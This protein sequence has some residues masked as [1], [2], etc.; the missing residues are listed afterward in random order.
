MAVPDK[1]HLPWVEIDPSLAH[2]GIPGELGEFVGPALGDN[3]KTK[4]QDIKTIFTSVMTTAASISM[5]PEANKEG[6]PG[7]NIVEETLRALN[8]LFERVLDRTQTLSTSTFEWCHATPPYEDL[9]LRP[10]RYPL[11]QTFADQVVHYLLGT[12]V[13][14]AEMNRNANHSSL[15][16]NTAE[17]IMAPMYHL[18]ALIA[19]DYFDKEVSGE[20]SLQEMIVLMTG[21]KKVGPTI[22]PSGESQELVD[23]A[24]LTDALSGIDLLQ[25][26]PNQQEWTTF[27]EKMVT[28]YHPERVWQPEGAI[29]T[30][31]DVASEQTI[32]AGSAPPTGTVG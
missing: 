20:I 23:N 22:V 15:D 27:G 17:R 30:T 12:L 1:F 3:P 6:P 29:A 10:V 4:N 32:P 5:S 9:H 13:E 14:T 31:E 21:V 7:R 18:K 8:F 24:E 26:Y 19:K 2:G 11:R 16:P 28:L 25:W